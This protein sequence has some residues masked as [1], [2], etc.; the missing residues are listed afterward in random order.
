M[1]PKIPKVL[2]VEDDPGIRTLLI[3]ALK[4]EPLELE[5]AC[6]GVD[7]LKM[8]LATSHAVILLD[9]MLPRM[10]GPEF[11]VAFRKARPKADPVILVMT[12]IDE[13]QIGKLAPH[14]VHA[15][16][17]KPFDIQL[18]VEMVRDCAQLRVSQESRELAASLRATTPAP[19]EDGLADDKSTIDPAFGLN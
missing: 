15:V 7:A 1:L 18:L 10:T 12:A 4:R 2:I 9:L 13:S 16:I 8:A 11:L 5:V 19:A 14:A 3:A 6:D 17:R